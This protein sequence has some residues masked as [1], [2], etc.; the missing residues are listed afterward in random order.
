MD[1][2]GAELYSLLFPCPCCAEK[3]AG[4]DLKKVVARRHRVKHNGKF[5][6]ALEDSQ[7]ILDEAGV[8]YEIGMPDER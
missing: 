6:N 4:T 8:E 2:A 7:R 5:E 1:L 3:I